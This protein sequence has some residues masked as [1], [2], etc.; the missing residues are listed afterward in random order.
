MPSFCA[1]ATSG[2]VIILGFNLILMPVFC[3]VA[4]SGVPQNG[5]HPGRATA[6]D[7]S[8]SLAKGRTRRN[9]GDAYRTMI[10]G[11]RKLWGATRKSLYLS[12]LALFRVVVSA[13]LKTVISLILNTLQGA[14]NILKTY[15]QKDRTAYNASIRNRRDAYNDSHQYGQMKR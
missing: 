9:C 7:D 11:Q 13:T 4:T 8:W 15:G 6:G 5:C 1:V 10:A 2:E 14:P 12:T 3:A